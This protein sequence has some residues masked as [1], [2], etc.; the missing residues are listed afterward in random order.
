MREVREEGNERPLRASA[1]RTGRRWGCHLILFAGFGLALGAAARANA[2]G[3]QAREYE[4]KA[5][6]LYNFTRFV[7]W[8]PEVFNSHPNVITEGVLGNNPFG[9]ALRSLEGKVVNG[10][11]LTVLPFKT[12]QEVKPCHVLFISGSEKNRLSQALKAVG[13]SSVLTVSEVK[14]FT[15]QGGI[16]NFHLKSGRIGFEINVKAAE[17][18]GLKI[19]S[20]LLNLA[21]LTGRKSGS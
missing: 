16:I 19:S 13:D 14:G 7:H 21:T 3:P 2:Q 5:A 1:G 20:K 9:E 11:K 8:P 10:R 12:V 17:R 15:E 4:V 6:F 18:A